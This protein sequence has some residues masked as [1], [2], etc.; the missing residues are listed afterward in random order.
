MTCYSLSP[1]LDK[2]LRDYIVE[3][4]PNVVNFDYRLSDDGSE[5][6][7]SGNVIS[8]NSSNVIEGINN[9]EK[10]LNATFKSVTDIKGFYTYTYSF[11]E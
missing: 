9:V 3:F 6:S 2:E 10:L 1:D 5:I 8:Y 7:L 11:N 4:H